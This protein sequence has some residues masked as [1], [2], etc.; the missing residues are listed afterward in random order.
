MVRY[1][2]VRL[3]MYKA[4]IADVKAKF[5]KDGEFHST[6]Y[7]ALGLFQFPMGGGG[8]KI[9]LKS[10]KSHTVSIPSLT[11]ILEEEGGRGGA[12]LRPP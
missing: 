2:E 5:R 1:P 12:N 3:W 4:D 11:E 7:L 6:L 8:L 9:V 10:K